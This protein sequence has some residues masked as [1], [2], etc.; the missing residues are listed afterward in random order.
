MAIGFRRNDCKSGR[1]NV[2]ISKGDGSGAERDDAWDKISINNI[3]IDHLGYV[4]VYASGKVIE[5]VF[6]YLRGV[7][8][9]FYDLSIKMIVHRMQKYIDLKGDYVEK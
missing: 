8:G 9:K 1:S 2:E 3:L 5:N 6:S 4:K 7:A